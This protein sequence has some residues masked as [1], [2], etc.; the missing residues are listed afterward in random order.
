VNI[1]EEDRWFGVGLLGL[2]GVLGVMSM[3][4]VAPRGAR[5]AF[6]GKDPEDVAELRRVMLEVL[7][8]LRAQHWDYWTSH[9]TAHGDSYYGD[10]LLLER[11]YTGDIV[12]EIDG[13]GE[14]MVAYFGPDV[15]SSP[16]VLQR[17]QHHVDDWS[18]VSH[19]FRRALK[20]EQRLQSALREAYD[21]GKRTNLLTLG[22]DDFLMGLASA[23]DTN[24]YLLKQRLRRRSSS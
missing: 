4:E 7:A 17:T 1:R 15:V 20:S 11:L 13:M 10:H 22:L 5:N 23:H 19:P 2:L 21:V 14:R 6:D 3:E 24:I 12:E 18:R 8:I 16:R 9:W